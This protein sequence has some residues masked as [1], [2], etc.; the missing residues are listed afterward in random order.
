LQAESPCPHS[1]LKCY[2][3]I[4]PPASSPVFGKWCFLF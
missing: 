3:V 1:S 2:I 4:N